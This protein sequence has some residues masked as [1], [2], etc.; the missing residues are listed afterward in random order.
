MAV[1]VGR[2]ASRI[3]IRVRNE[4]EFRRIK[5]VALKIALSEITVLR[6]QLYPLKVDKVSRP[7][8][9]NKNGSL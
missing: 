6:D 2:Q 5:E 9:L 3:I 1:Y 7:A 4:A 8:V